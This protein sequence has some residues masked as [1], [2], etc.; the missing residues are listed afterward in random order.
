M[1]SRP[2]DDEDREFLE[3][4]ADRRDWIGI[5]MKRFTDRSEAG[6]RCM[7]QKV[8]AE[9]GMGDKRTVDAPWMADAINGTR[10]L[11]E[12]LVETGLRP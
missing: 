1:A 8:R 11:Y 7:M 9:L 4:L 3:E 5:A 12:R 10:R 6:V 2:W